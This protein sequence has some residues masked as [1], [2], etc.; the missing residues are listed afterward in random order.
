[1]VGKGDFTI[2]ILLCPCLHHAY[3]EWALN[4]GWTQV[5]THICSF[6]L[7]GVTAIAPHFGSEMIRIIQLN[8]LKSKIYF[9]RQRL[10]GSIL[11]S[12]VHSTSTWLPLYMCL[13]C[14]GSVVGSWAGRG[15]SIGLGVAGRT[16]AP[17]DVSQSPHHQLV[18]NLHHH[19]LCC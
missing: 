1:M 8:L 11:D 5:R 17:S 19:H 2:V 18:G 10:G 15:F 4:L 12:V 3:G 9:M 14:L 16:D 13:E 7:G 6:G